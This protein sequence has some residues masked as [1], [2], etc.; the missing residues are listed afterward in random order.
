VAALSLT[1]LFALGGGG[2]V[3]GNTP[4]PEVRIRPA[5]GGATLVRP[6]LGPATAAERL[7]RTATGD[8]ATGETAGGDARTTR[9]PVIP[10]TSTCAATRGFRPCVG[11]EDHHKWGHA[12]VVDPGLPDNPAHQGAIVIE[13][14]AVDCSQALGDSGPVR[15]GS[16]DHGSKSDPLP[17]PST[18]GATR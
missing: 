13:Q 17:S 1:G 3:P 6:I 2:A 15:C 4:G 5:E 11:T 9:P 8:R 16:V 10:D 18:E 14:D 12:I 7:A